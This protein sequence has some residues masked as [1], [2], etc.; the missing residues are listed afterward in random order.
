MIENDIDILAAKLAER[1]TTVPR[2]MKLNQAVAY[3]NIGKDR[4]IALAKRGHI[5][6]GQDPDLKSKPWIFDR[7]SIDEYRAKQMSN[8]P[9]N[10]AEEFALDFITRI[11]L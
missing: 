3:S 2:W 6:G 1:L 7:K 5:N 9:Q 10:D 11:G 4:L 8:S